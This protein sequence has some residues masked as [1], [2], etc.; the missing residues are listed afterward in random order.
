[1]NGTTQTSVKTALRWGLIAAAALCTLNGQTLI[2]LS[3]Q[4]RNVDFSGANATKPVQT[5]STL[6]ATCSQGQLFFNTSAPAG[7]NFYGC[8]AN[9]TWSLQGGSA[10]A[11]NDPGTNGLLVRTAPNTA[12]VVSAPAG[13]VVG[14]TDTQ[15]LTNK[16]IDASEINS[17]TFSISRMPALSGDVTTVAGSTTT[18]LATVNANTGTFGDSS[19]SVQV[20]V[21]GKGRIT[22]IS[23]IPAAAS[24]LVSGALASLPSTCSAG[25]LYF[26]ADQPAGQQIYTCSSA[27]TW[28]QSM[29]LGGSGALAVNNGALD[30]VTSVVPR[31][32]AA[33]TFSGFNSFSALQIAGSSTNPGCASTSDVGKIW[34]NTTSSTNTAYQVCLAVSGTVQWVTK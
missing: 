21:D 15:T 10:N 33:N 20:T 6:P 29:S 11:I 2:N 22:Q 5:G 24:A 3:T 13:A 27:N 18:T 26:A 1:M 32:A 28:T 14:T 23:A 31:L 16:S 4:G 9:N 25:S 19:H 7:Q 17:G 8:S 12:T 30:I 34:I